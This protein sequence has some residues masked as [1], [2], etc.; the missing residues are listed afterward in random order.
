MWFIIRAHIHVLSKQA[1]QDLNNLQLE[2]AIVFEKYQFKFLF[3]KHKAITDKILIRMI[4]LDLKNT[5]Q[6]YNIPFNV[7]SHSF[8]IN[9]V[10]NLRRVISVQKAAEIRGHQDVRSTMSYQRYA[11]SKDEIKELLNKIENSK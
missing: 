1:I 2:F 7:K 4:N 6:K 3:G 9:M 10:T 5:C 8:W 11:L